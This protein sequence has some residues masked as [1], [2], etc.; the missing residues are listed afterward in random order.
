MNQQVTISAYSHFRWSAHHK[1]YQFSRKVNNETAE[2]MADVFQDKGCASTLFYQ[3][4]KDTWVEFERVH[5][6]NLHVYDHTSLWY[7]LPDGVLRNWGQLSDTWREYFE[8]IVKVVEIEWRKKAKAARELAEKAAKE[9][10]RKEAEEI[11][12]TCE[13]EWDEVIY[14]GTSYEKCKK[15]KLE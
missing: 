8:R 15:Q 5:T 1:I 14:L 2:F 3:R 13:E 6:E 10:K 7:Y 11:D 12:L 9:L 4:F